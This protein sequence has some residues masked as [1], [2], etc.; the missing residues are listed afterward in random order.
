MCMG[1]Y[2]LYMSSMMLY[3]HCTCAANRIQLLLA[4]INS[5]FLHSNSVFPQCFSLHF[6]VAIL[7]NTLHYFWYDLHVL[8][9]TKKFL[10]KYMEVSTM[11]KICGSLEKCSMKLK[12][13]SQRNLQKIRKNVRKILQVLN[14]FLVKFMGY[15]QEILKNF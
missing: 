5:V 2:K 11:S 1:F 3:L 9:I 12:E 10:V 13:N 15:L 7:R 4:N 6:S 14:Q 8:E